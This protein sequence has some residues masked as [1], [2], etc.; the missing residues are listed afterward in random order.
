MF[1][2]LL[3]IVSFAV[4]IRLNKYTEMKIKSLLKRTLLFTLGLASVTSCI[5]NDYDLS[6]DINLEITIGGEL[7]AFP[8]GSMDTVFMTDL[9]DTTENIKIE[10]GHFVLVNSEVMSP[11]S[12]SVSDITL[13]P[14]K[15]VIPEIY[16]EFFDIMP[17]MNIEERSTTELPGKY[18]K[19][20]VISEGNIFK[21]DNEVPDELVK[22]KKVYFE[23]GEE[24]ECIIN[25]K[26]KLN[27]TV[28][29]DGVVLKDLQCHLP[30]FFEFTSMDEGVTV[31]GDGIVSINEVVDPSDPALRKTL[32]IKSV[33]FT[34]SGASGLD[35]IYED[36][37]KRLKEE[38]GINIYGDVILKVSMVEPLSM[39]YVYEGSL[40]AEMEIEEMNLSQ[41]NGIFIPDMDVVNES[42]KI[43]LGEDC[44]F[45][46]KDAVL[47]FTNPQI[48]ITFE[49]N[50][51]IPAVAEM[52]IWGEDENGMMINGS[53]IT[54][55][56][57]HIDAADVCGI[58]KTT[59]WMISK[60]SKA[61]EGYNHKQVEDLP[62]LWNV[63]PDRIRF[64]MF[65]VAEGDDHYIDLN[66]PMSFSGNYDLK[67][68]L[69]FDNLNLTYTE[70][71]D[72][73]L[74]DLKDISGLQESYTIH[75]VGNVENA[76]EM[77]MN[78]KAIPY[79]K[80]G[81]EIPSSLVSATVEN[82]IIAGGGADAAVVSPFKVILLTNDKGLSLLERID[83]KITAVSDDNYDSVLIT[84]SQYLIMK[85]MKLRIIGGITI[86]AN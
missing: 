11:S 12:V 53:E 30:D 7:L 55:S 20:E 33:D 37:V 57:I 28:G 4:K 38:V 77:N 48:Y 5:N 74:S 85:D 73:L 65:P 23:E 52:K 76:L 45:L 59:K 70:T 36:G 64:T 75:L 14:D 72:G 1:C 78:I 6:K 66:K 62:A 47:N 15:T 21:F 32:K 19:S 25:I 79:D 58:E 84:E 83:L 60:N 22:L 17:M 80:D 10:N 26:L 9:I 39:S 61:K 69:E 13:T 35:A 3:N 67:A 44:D 40:E 24:P 86:D 71:I 54:I 42:I 51:G 63:I 16:L 34:K 82:E 2:L 49:N 27:S 68:P 29:L 43:E 41:I 18:L 31:V 81:N 56:D 8:L 50:V 46:K